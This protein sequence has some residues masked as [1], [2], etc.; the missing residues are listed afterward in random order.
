[1]DEMK[2]RGYHPDPQWECVNW[3]GNILGLDTS[4][5]DPDTVEEYYYYA[6]EKGE[7]IY[8]EHNDDYLYECIENLKSKGVDVIEMEKLL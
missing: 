7:M 8:P 1:M 5:A 4:F 3:R 6:K 2:R